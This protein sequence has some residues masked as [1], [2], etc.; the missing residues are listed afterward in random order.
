MEI[1]GRR[2]LWVVILSLL[3]FIV[4]SLHR[5]HFIH[6]HCYLKAVQ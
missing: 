6:C 4:D 1:S 5:S 2:K 3:C